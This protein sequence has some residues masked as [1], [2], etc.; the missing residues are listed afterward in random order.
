MDGWMEMPLLEGFVLVRLREG[1]GREG[2]SNV[3]VWVDG[4]MDGWMDVV[5]CLP[6]CFTEC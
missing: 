6:A 1:K 3:C 5:P 2:V 4:W